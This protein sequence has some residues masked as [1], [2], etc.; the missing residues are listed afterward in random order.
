[1]PQPPKILSRRSVTDSEMF[2]VEAVDLEF[3]NGE[4]RYYEYLLSGTFPAVIIVAMINHSE[5]LLVQEFGIGL[6]EYQWGL[7]KGRVD[8]GESLI[9]AANRELQEEAGYAAKSLTVLKTLSQSPNYMQHKIHIV[10]AE[11]LYKSKLEGDEPEPLAVQ[12]IDLKQLDSVIGRADLS[13]ARSI[14]ALYIVRD[15]LRSVGRNGDET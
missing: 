5:C 15:W 1:M 8:E 11:D 13:E 4:R 14:A 2:K 7:P 6:E 9:E 12:R 10:L 3:S